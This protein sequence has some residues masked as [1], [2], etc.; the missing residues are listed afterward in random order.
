MGHAKSINNSIRRGFLHSMAAGTHPP[1]SR[2]EPDYRPWVSFVDGNWK[3]G[4]SGWAMC[5]VDNATTTIVRQSAGWWWTLAERRQLPV[6]QVC[7]ICI[8]TGREDA[9][10]LFLRS[11]AGRS[12]PAEHDYQECP[13]SWCSSYNKNEIKT[14]WSVSTAHG[15]METLQNFTYQCVHFFLPLLYVLSFNNLLFIQWEVNCH[16]IR[17]GLVSVRW[18]L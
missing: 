14:F 2:Y 7:D 5:P 3:R 10:G 16:C 18:N 17:G 13:Y 11:F 4:K 15:W 1:G 8:R 12:K 9:S 6:Q